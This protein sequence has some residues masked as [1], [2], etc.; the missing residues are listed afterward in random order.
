MKMQDILTPQ[1][2]KDVMDDFL[3]IIQAKEIYGISL[4]YWYHRL[5]CEL[6]DIE[7]NFHD[8]YNDMLITDSMQYDI[9]YTKRMDK[10]LNCINYK[11]EEKIGAKNGKVRE[12]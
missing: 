12:I 4:K 7:G 10:I 9:A 5:Y 8:M 2:F 11:I 6:D 3:H 1:K